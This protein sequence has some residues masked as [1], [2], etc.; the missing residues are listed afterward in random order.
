MKD[1]RKSPVKPY[2]LP[3]TSGR[4][5]GLWNC[6][7]LAQW[8]Y[9]GTEIIGIAADETERQ[10]E[11]LPKIVR[12]TSHRIVFLYIGAVFVL[13]LN[14]SSFDPVLQSIPPSTNPIL[15]GFVVMV[16]RSG[17]PSLAHIIYAGAL[18][19]A[20]SVANA[21]LYVTVYHILYHD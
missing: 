16:Q 10:R 20:L 1:W 7:L 15:S 6:C 3:G 21:S 11:T 17:L 4:L 9:I 13:G 12:R 8:A 19:A 2:L 5:L 14:V 18:I